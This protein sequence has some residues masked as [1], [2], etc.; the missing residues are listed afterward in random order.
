MID[1]DFPW[2][3]RCWLLAVARGAT[4]GGI[5]WF[6]SNLLVN[7]LTAMYFGGQYSVESMRNKRGE[8]YIF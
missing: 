6:L 8:T 5:P 4:N 3:K 1:G 7:E 2:V